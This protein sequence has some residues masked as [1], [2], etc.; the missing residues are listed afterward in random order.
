MR[1]V[2]CEGSGQPYVK[3]GAFKGWVCPVCRK[4]IGT[5]GRGYGYRVTKLVPMHNRKASR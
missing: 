3:A 2:P 4:A 1:R 5:V